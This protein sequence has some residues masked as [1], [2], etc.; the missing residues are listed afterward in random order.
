MELKKSSGGPALWQ[1]EFSYSP[2]GV[3]IFG[4]QAT[5]A[6]TRDAILRQTLF[7]LAETPV[8]YF[9][10]SSKSLSPLPGVTEFKG[11]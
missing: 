1:H 3:T 11:K 10:P 6:T 9:V 2:K 8:P 7:Q 5:D 4:Q